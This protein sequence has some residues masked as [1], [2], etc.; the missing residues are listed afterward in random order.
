MPSVLMG[1]ESKTLYKFINVHQRDCH[2]GF[3]DVM[4]LP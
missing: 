3:K 2:Y 4:H 1:T